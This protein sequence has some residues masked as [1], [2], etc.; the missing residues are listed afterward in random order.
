MEA[1][2]IERFDD[3]TTSFISNRLLQLRSEEGTNTLGRVLTLVIRT[4]EAGVEA[5][6]HAAVQASQEH[7]M[8][9]IAVVEWQP[10]TDLYAPHSSSRNPDTLSAELRSGEGAG[11]SEVII[12][13]PQ[14]QVSENVEY[15]VTGLLI[16]DTPIVV[17]WFTVWPDHPSA[18]REIATRHIFDSGSFHGEAIEHLGA[19]REQFHTGDTDLSWARLTLWRAQLAAMLDN[20]TGSNVTGITVNG[21]PDSSSTMLL[22]AWLSQQ[23][24]APVT[25]V[26]LAPGASVAWGIHAVTLSLEDG[27]AAIRRTHGAF[28]RIEQP[29]HPALEVPLPRRSLPDC[30]IEDLR[31]LG[32]DELF[33]Q[34]MTR[35][36]TN[37]HR[38]QT[39]TA[40]EIITEQP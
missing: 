6:V 5:S 21:T 1:S 30:L 20:L 17:W 11:A 36:F 22:A 4:T 2:M 27:E 29:D 31:I 35:G 34:V 3:T 32:V 38:D 25:C 12:L 28:A 7:P 33:E 26:D 14:G 16:S 24:D 19:L 23:L 39:R 9:I 18:F 15:L 13:R 8:R 10:E 37:V 40:A